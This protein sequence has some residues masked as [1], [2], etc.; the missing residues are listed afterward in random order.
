VRDRATGDPEAIAA[1]Y[2]T[3]RLTSGQGGLSGVPIIDVRPYRD[4]MPNGDFHLKF[5]SFSLRE[6]L[7][8]ANGGFANEVMLTASATDRSVTAYATAKMDEWLTN[9]EKDSSKGPVSA[10]VVRAKPADLNDTCFLPGGERV[11]E[12]QT[13]GGGRCNEAFRA[14]PSPHMVAGGPA[15]NDVLKCALKPV[16]FSEYHADFSAAEKERLKSI[17]PRGVCDFSQPGVGQQ[18][19]GGTW[20]T[21]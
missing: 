15:A 7:R 5:H 14:F 4:Q 10:K 20:L 12:S 8:K 1:A 9:L 13:F 21:F 19:L 16:D 18:Q 3:G 11:T 17:F 2:R 6:R